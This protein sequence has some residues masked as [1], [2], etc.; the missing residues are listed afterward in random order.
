MEK[1]QT[2]YDDRKSFY[3][4]AQTETIGTQLV[5]WSYDTKV[6]YIENGKAFVLGTYSQTTLRHIKEFLRQNCFKAD[7]K[8]QIVA[9]YM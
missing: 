1:L 5:L 8:K 6:S 9:D 2:I 4:K 3:G 7:S